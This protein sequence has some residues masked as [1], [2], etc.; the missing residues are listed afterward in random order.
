LIK[1]G[2]VLKFINVV[3][4]CARKQWLTWAD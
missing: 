3:S 4:K 1:K 2:E